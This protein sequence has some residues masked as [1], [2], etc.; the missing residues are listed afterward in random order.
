MGSEHK[1][2]R[3]EGDGVFQKKIQQNGTHSPKY[4]II[5]VLMH[6]TLNQHW[7][8]WLHLIQDIQVNIKLYFSEN[9]GRPSLKKEFHG[10]LNQIISKKLMEYWYQELL[11]QAVLVIKL[12]TMEDD[13]KT[14][15]K[16]I[17]CPHY[18]WGQW[19]FSQWKTSDNVLFLFQCDSL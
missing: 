18:F 3:F 12:P 11:H 5:S 4:Q 9:R 10:V 1:Q 15:P 7:F 8:L 6:L 16:I 14:P 13:N 19:N 17:V 2:Q